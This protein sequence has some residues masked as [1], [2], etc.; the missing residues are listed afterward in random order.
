MLRKRLAINQWLSLFLLMIGVAMVQWPDDDEDMVAENAKTESSRLVGLLAVLASCFSSGYSGVYF[1]K[2]V[3]HTNQS[4]WVR[5]IQLAI[6]G[7]LLAVGAVLIQDKQAVQVGGFFQV[8]N[9]YFYILS[10]L[11]LIKVIFY[12][13][14]YNTLTWL[15]ILL[16][17]FGGLI[18]AI[19]M[20]YAD[21]IL[22]GFATSISIVLSTICSYYLLDDFAPSL[23][24]FF[25]A[26]IVISA[27][28]L[29]SC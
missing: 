7:F 15:V 17:A 20:K 3:K 9:Q 25:G 27:T 12:L 11:L 2:L 28:L 29:Y 18:V 5:N 8:K 10:F 19:V 23:S 26:S 14:G 22:K 4:L 24:F 6:F 13:Q 16:Q 1:E 21:N